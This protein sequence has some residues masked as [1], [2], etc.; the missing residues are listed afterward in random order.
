MAKEIRRARDAASQNFLSRQEITVLNAAIIGLGWWG[1]TL[2]E[3]VQS[4]GRR[5]RFTR[6]ATL[7][8][9]ASTAFAARHGLNVVEDYHAVLADPAI[10]A[11][12]IATPHS[13]HVDQIIA[14]AAA[15]KHVFSEKPLALNLADARR[16]V[17]ACVAAGVVLGV[18][19]DRRL[20]PGIRAMKHLV[21]SGAL[22]EIV[23][24]EAQYS[25]DVMSRGL[26]GAWR[27]DDSEAPGGGMTGPGLH[28]LDSLLNLGPGLKAVTGRINQVKPFPNPIDAVALLLEFEGG[29]TGTLGTVRGVPDFIRLHVLGTRG[30][31]EL[32]DFSTLT[33]HR[34]GEAATQAIHDPRLNTGEMLECFAQA[35]ACEVPFPV[36]SDAMLR[37]VA[38]FEA[39]VASLKLGN[40]VRVA[41]VGQ[42]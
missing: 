1:R 32:R 6:A 11:V 29:V 14:A 38:A 19:H 9:G 31:A 16:A 20:L 23:H 42:S 8:P 28:A 40:T 41:A 24:M 39:S 21:D 10:E 34:L 22:G 26:T 36:S 17:D 25:N 5:I 37:T 35:V 18:G 4:T 2:V 12:V 27:A 33:V 3:S 15:G 13:L 7:D 30:W